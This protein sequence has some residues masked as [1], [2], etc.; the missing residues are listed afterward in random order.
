MLVVASDIHL[1]DE[2]VGAVVSD[3]TFALFA[4]RLREL[5]YQ[6]SWRAG[7]RYDPVR[8]VDIILLGDILDP[9][10]STLWFEKKPGQEGY[11]RPW[12]DPQSELFIRKV[13]EITRAIL[14]KNRAAV[15]VL[16]KLSQGDGEGIRLP[17]ADR[18]GKPALYTRERVT[19]RVRI[20]YMVGNH[21]WYYHLPGKAYDAI[22]AEI[23]EAMGL[24][25]LPGPFPH[26]PE[27]AGALGE[28][29]ER[30]RLVARHG[31]RY[32]PMSYNPR[33]GRDSATLADVYTLEV[34]YRFPHEVNLQLGDELP[35]MLLQGIQR[36]INVRPLLATPLW[37]F[38]Q[39]RRHGASKAHY[40]QVKT[41]WDTVCEDFLSL[42]P[43]R[44]SQ[45]AA[46]VS[47][48]VLRL[49]F[50]LSKRAP[51][52]TVATISNLLRRYMPQEHISIARF[53]HQE[54]AIRAGRADFVTY[55]HTHSH[56]VVS[57]EQRVQDV[58]QSGQVYINT[59]AWATFYDYYHRSAAAGEQKTRPMHLL[60]CVALYQ[61]GERQGR[62]YENW[63]ANFA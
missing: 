38:D 53:A 46:P 5:A 31:D 25:N 36:M 54:S 33:A 24:D 6:A 55:G 45:F 52:S 13:A 29:F 41:M 42:E 37:L 18:R 44:N 20:Y 51:F 3:K 57:L 32:D 62:R 26:G 17:P 39:V 16:K 8:E 35:P 50:G 15:D 27:D 43:L 59:G 28:T 9:L 47:R 21:D 14:Q 34:L 23:I 58:Q 56:E 60:T 2:T 49:I 22:R 4:S 1:S 11:V 19:P 48:N 7:G 10:Q 12:H 61:D 30:Y 40:G 63:W